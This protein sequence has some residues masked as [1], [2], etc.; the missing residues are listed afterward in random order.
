MQAEV[1]YSDYR[2]YKVFNKRQCRFYAILVS[3]EDR[4]TIAWAKY[5]LEVSLGR[6][7]KRGAICHHID[8]NKTKSCA[9]KLQ[10]LKSLQAHHDLP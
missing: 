8:L 4:T 7:L 6:K 2:V 9:A 5:L 3:S 1:P 10:G